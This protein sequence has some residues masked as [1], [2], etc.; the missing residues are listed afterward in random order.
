MGLY[1]E[2]CM[3]KRYPV[4]CGRKVLF[5]AIIVGL[6]LLP[7]GMGD[8]A[9]GSA[10]LNRY[11]RAVA[12][13]QSLDKGA[14]KEKEVIPQEVYSQD[15]TESLIHHPDELYVYKVVA[16]ELASLDKDIPRA[17]LFEAYAR[18]GLGQTLQG[19]Q[20]LMDYVAEAEESEDRHY[21]LIVENLAALEDWTAVYIICLEWEEKKSDCL[22]VRALYEW[23]ALT[24]LKRHETALLALARNE[25]C[26]GWKF[27]VYEAMSTYSTGQKKNAKKILTESKKKFPEHTR[28]I[29]NLWYKMAPSKMQSLLDE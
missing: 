21:L 12:V 24:E 8:E 20:L 13:L 11:Y 9:Q 14:A 3:K 2:S 26:L 22:Q 7:L 29:A 23:K 5:F 18:L 6:S 16:A 10:D 28:Q 19:A 17:K 15:E 4:L 25:N 1:G 27:P